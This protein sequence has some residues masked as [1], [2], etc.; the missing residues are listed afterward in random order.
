MGYI[1]SYDPPTPSIPPGTAVESRDPSVAIDTIPNG[2][3]ASGARFARNRAG[4]GE[5][6]EEDKRPRFPCRRL[7]SSE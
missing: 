6:P 4:V 1:E 3:R 2:R 7:S 5:E